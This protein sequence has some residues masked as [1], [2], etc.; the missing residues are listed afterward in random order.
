MELLH[1]ILLKMQYNN[2]LSKIHLLYF[3]KDIN[4][5]LFIEKVTAYS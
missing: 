4:E 1:L 2:I 3:L 5:Y